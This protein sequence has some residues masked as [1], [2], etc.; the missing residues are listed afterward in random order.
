M[1]D[2]TPITTQD[3]FDKAVQARI[4][5]ERDKFKDFDTFKDKAA[6]FDALAGKDYEGT[7][8]DLQEQLK[9]AN[10]TLTAMTER[11]DT[12]EHSLMISRVAQEF[13]LPK[14]LADRLTG[15]TE[16]ELRTDAQALAKFVTPTEP[17]PLANPEP[18]K[19]DQ[20]EAAY[21][22]LL[23]GLKGD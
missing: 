5:R 11:A 18:V 3:E 10:E 15:S 14:E 22:T 7:I 20:I 1:A 12:A 6:K 8:K 19:T 4:Q 13:K 17:A 16:E 23:S 21:M 2:F 9:T